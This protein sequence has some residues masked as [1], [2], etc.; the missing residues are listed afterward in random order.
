MYPTRPYQ[1]YSFVVGFFQQLRSTLLLKMLFKLFG[2]RRCCFLLRSFDSILTFVP[3]ALWCCSLQ[4]IIL[5]VKFM[6]N[7]FHLQSGCCPN[8]ILLI[9][10]LSCFNRR[11]FNLYLPLQP[12]GFSQCSSLSLFSNGVFSNLSSPLFFFSKWLNLSRFFGLT[13]LAKK[14]LSF[15]SPL[16]LPL[17]LRC[18]S[19]SR[20]EILS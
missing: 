9:P 10:S 14:Q 16:Y 12:Q 11:G 18:H 1:A 17:S 20:D 19:R 8:Y 6:C 4:P 7:S 3:G 15:T 13:R 2:G 5:F